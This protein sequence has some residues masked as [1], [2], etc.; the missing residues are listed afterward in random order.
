MAC[1]FTLQK[2][3]YILILCIFASIINGE[4][5][6]ENVKK[7]NE[8]KW[9][10]KD[11]R[12]YSEADL[13]RL[14]DQWEDADEDE[15]PEDELPEWKRE[16]PK[17]DMSKL[18]TA[19]PEGM[20]KATKK[21]K[22]LMMFASVSGNPTQDET[23]KVTQIWAGSLFNANIE[24]QR[25]VVGENRVIFMLKDGA[26]AWEVKD[27]LVKQDRCEEV[28]IEGKSYPGKGASKDKKDSNKTKDNK[29]GK[30]T[31]KSK[32]KTKSSDKND[33]K[34]NNKKKTEL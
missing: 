29:K 3:Y 34:S 8:D 30:K 6:D 18:N 1:T 23:E 7:Q 4:T 16:P 17:V 24:T 9:K 13:E 12:D 28:T 2:F 20:L 27:F 15:L 14:Y 10:K 26:M 22:T 21:G 33:N 32:G 19:D 11:I 5:K 25:Y 31:E